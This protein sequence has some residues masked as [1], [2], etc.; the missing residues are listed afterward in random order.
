MRPLYDWGD[1]MDSGYIVG[2]IG[3]IAA[4]VF[5]YIAFIRDRDKD[6]TDGAK[7]DATVL[8]EI[9]YIKANTDE[10][11][12]EQKEQRKTNIE[13]ITRLTAVE[14]SARQAHNRIDALEG[15]EARREA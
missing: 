3:S 10:I 6:K 12:A 2:S 9:G 5:G 8:T 13:F 14:A 4:I 11:K 15:K 1:I 7:S